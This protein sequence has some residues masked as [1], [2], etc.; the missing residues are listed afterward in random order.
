MMKQE[1]ESRFL[2][3]K[4]RSIL[5]ASLAVEGAAY[6]VSLTDSLV[7]GNMVGTQALAA[8]SLAAP[9]AFITTFLASMI[10]SGTTVSYSYCIGRYDRKQA[11]EV[12]SQ[13]TL[14]AAA[15]GA[16]TLIA[17]ECGSGYL[18]RSWG[19]PE[20]MQTYLRDYFRIF[21]VYLSLEPLSVLLDNMVLSDGGERLSATANIAEMGGNVLLSLLFG[22]IWG[23]AGIALASVVCKLVFF[24]IIGAWF[25]TP[26]NN[27]AFGFCFRMTDGLRIFRNGI[28]KASPIIY[29][30]LTAFTL[31]AFVMSQFGLDSFVL[32]SLALRIVGASSLFIGLSQAV[33]PLAGTLRGEQNTLALRGLMRTAFLTLFTV[34]ALSSAVTFVFARQFVRGFG[35]TDPALL[36]QGRAVL[37]MA[38]SSFVFQALASQLFIYYYLIEKRVPS[39]LISVI[40]DLAAPLMI[41]ITASLLSHNVTG[42][43]LG[44]ASAPAVALAAVLVF[45]RCRYG[46]D[47]FPLL[48]PNENDKNI[49]IYDFNL[50]QDNELEDTASALSETVVE[51]LDTHGSSKRTQTIAGMLLEDTILLIAGQNRTKQ[52]LRAECTVMINEQ[53]VRLILRDSGEITDIAGEQTKMDSLRRYVVMRMGEAL[54]NKAYLTTTGYNR[55]EFYIE[56]RR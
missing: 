43:W 23:V 29:K 14:M 27:L 55:N 9:F 40:K 52:P 7:A 15:A 13:G 45:V 48:L 44:L 31:N 6:L 47:L 41:G 24:A 17:F 39:F 49:F 18:V 2:N 35:I 46:R 30:A 53:G 54:D 51:L 28:V 56:E 26:Q 11:N 12:F 50:A 22:R 42:V 21:C 32:L 16:V 25:F 3:R 10:N 5:K 4:Y 20:L 36:T 1:R 33:S 19:G 34:G 38:G 37:R 8:V